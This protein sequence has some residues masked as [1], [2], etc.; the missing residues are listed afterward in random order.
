MKYLQCL[1][2]GIIFHE[3]VGSEGFWIISSNR[4]GRRMWHSVEK[5]PYV[6]PMIP[7]PDNTTQQI[8]EPLSKMI[9]INKKQYIVDVRVMNY[10]LQAIPNDIYNS[11]DASKE[12]ESLEFVYERL[13]M[14]VNI[15]DHNNVHPIP[16][17]TTPS[18]SIACNL[19][20]ANMLP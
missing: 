13:T 15:L 1:R 3:R 19:S 11:V 17:S 20:G 16:V 9:E 8:I 10:L 5:G 14:L 4:G 7:D 2:N 12:G 18:F 6:R